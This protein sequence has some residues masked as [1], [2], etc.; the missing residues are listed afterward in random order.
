MR[1]VTSTNLKNEI[2]TKF[3]CPMYFTLSLIKGR[4]K[5]LI[6]YSLRNGPQ[7]FSELR[8]S[9]GKASERLYLGHLRELESDGLV[10]KMESSNDSRIAMYSLTSK[11][12]SLM[13]VLSGLCTWGAENSTYPS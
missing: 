12:E 7:R 6:L 11:G 3:E 8:K 2:E 13:D 9:V 1:K 4:W 5:P 10:F